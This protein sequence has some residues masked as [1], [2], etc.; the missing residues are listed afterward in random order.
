MLWWLLKVQACHRGLLEAARGLAPPFWA[1]KE[2]RSR[3]W[4]KGVLLFGRVTWD[5]HLQQA[6]SKLVAWSS[7]Y[8][9]TMHLEPKQV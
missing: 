7:E 2:G 8:D 1:Y 4:I 9:S 5:V 6:Q 3:C